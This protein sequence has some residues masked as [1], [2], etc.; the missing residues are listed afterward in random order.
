M[1]AFDNRLPGLLKSGR[2]LKGMFI[3]M[4]SPALVEMAG[5]AGFD[6]VIIDNE[7]GNSSLESTEHMIRAAKGVGI[8]PIVRTLES[9]ILHVLDIGASGIKIP[10]VNTAEKAR[11]VV[12]AA[13]YPPVGT[14]GAAFSARA[15]GYGFFGGEPQAKAANEGTAVI[16]MIE[17]LEAIE[18]LDE[19]L[20][21][22]GI[23]C[24][25]V[26]PNDLSFSMG[27][28][29]QVRHP[30]VKA[31]VEGAIRRIRAKGVAAGVVAINN[32]DA[33]HFK[34][35]GANYL[36]TSWHVVVMT[37]FKGVSAA[38]TV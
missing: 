29:T 33:K 8:I 35:V 4:P 27:Y 38:L 24:A 14:R 37:A 34:E 1:T 31:A 36:T 32:E 17:T 11:R 30:E 20:A 6:M 7:H 18:N 28:P 19:I 21:V 22:P 10:A 12:A 9:S 2:V 13:K 25:F 15:A 26:G 16:I 23:D 5:Y 3:G